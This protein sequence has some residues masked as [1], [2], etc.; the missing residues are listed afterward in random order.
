VAGKG[1]SG[2]VVEQVEDFHVGAVGQ[3]PVG[4]IGL[5]ELVG[6]FGLE[7]FP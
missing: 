6:Q 1:E 5:P 7:A 2:V 4:D 3:V